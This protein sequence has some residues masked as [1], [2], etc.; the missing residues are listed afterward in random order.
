MPLEPKIIAFCCNWCSY[1]AADLAGTARMR[2]PES[3]R[4][5]RMMCSG[6]VH[7][8]LVIAAMNM[9]ADAVMIL[10]CRLGECHYI[11]GNHKALARSDMIIELL[12]DLGYE[13]ERF[14]LHWLSSAEP[15]VFVAAVTETVERIRQ[16]SL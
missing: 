8:E 9:G 11:D 4:I 2:Y 10:G 7:P 1:A 13:K 3:V 15:D 12:E 16:L 14:S 5:I 6:M